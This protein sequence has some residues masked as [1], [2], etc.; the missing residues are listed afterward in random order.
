[1]L[2]E[3]WLRELN[4]DSSH[5][6]LGFDPPFLS[7]LTLFRLS[8]THPNRTIGHIVPWEM[9][10]KISF[11]SLVSSQ[12]VHDKVKGLLARVLDNG[13]RGVERGGEGTTDSLADQLSRNC[14]LV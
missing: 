7:P 3:Q 12:G 10:G 1:V 14:Y 11:R 5:D 6:I 8:F 13:I 9:L 2:L 4:S